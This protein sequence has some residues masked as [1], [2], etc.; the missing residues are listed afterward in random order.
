MSTF[1]NDFFVTTTQGQA[2]PGA[3]VYY[4]T[5]QSGATPQTV[6]LMVP[7]TLYTDSTGATT[8][9][10]PVI[11]D[12]FGHA[13]TG[14]LNVAPYLAAGTY[15]IAVVL[16]NGSIYEVLNDQLIGASGGGS[17]ISVFGR[18]GNVISA[19]NDY[20]FSQ[21]AGTITV[22]QLTG[23][24]F[25]ASGSSHSI[26]VVPDP[27]A[28]SGTTRFLREDA[29]WVVPSGSGGGGAGSNGNI[30]WNFDNAM[31]G[32]S[33]LNTDGNSLFAKGPIPYRDITSFEGVVGTTCFSPE[34]VT[35]S[36]TS[37]SHTL[38]V[39]G[40][41]WVNGCSVGVANAG[42]ATSLS[43]PTIASAAF[44]PATMQ[45]VANGFTRASN[46][47]HVALVND[48][49]IAV[50]DSVLIS[51]ATGCSTSPNI[52]ATVASTNWVAGA[53]NSNG[54]IFTFN[55]SGAN[56]TCGGNNGDGTGPA[57]LIV[58]PASTH[59]SYK[60][61]A[62]DFNNG[63]TAPSSAATI[64]T[65]VPTLQGMEPNTVT[66]NCVAGAAT[67]PVWR[68][69][70]GTGNFVYIGSALPCMNGYARQTTTLIDFGQ[71]FGAGTIPQIPVGVP[72][73]APS[74]A[75][76]QILISQITAGGGTDTLTLA[77]TASSSVSSTTTYHDNTTAFN[78]A[79]TAARTDYGGND[80]VIPSTIQPRF[81]NIDL[82]TP[83]V[84]PDGVFNPIV[85]IKV[86]GGLWPSCVVHK[87]FS[88]YNLIGTG[89]W[90]GDS[91]F[92]KLET[93][94]SF[95]TGDLNPTIFD[96]SNHSLIKGFTFGNSPQ[97]GPGLTG[98]A[99]GLSAFTAILMG[100][101]SDNLYSDLTTGGNGNGIS[102][103]LV[104]DGCSGSGG[105]FGLSFTRMNFDGSVNFPV[106]SAAFHCSGD[107]NL[108]SIFI[109]QRPILFDSYE[110]VADGGG[111]FINN[112]QGY[113]G[114]E[115]VHEGYL[116][117]TNWAN[118]TNIGGVSI[119]NLNPADSLYGPNGI[120]NNVTSTSAGTLVINGS[121]ISNNLVSG[122]PFASALFTNIGESG[123]GIQSKG[124]YAN[125]GQSA[126][127]IFS[128]GAG[129]KNT[130][131][132]VLSGSALIGSGTQPGGA[133][134]ITVVDQ[135]SGGTGFSSSSFGGDSGGQLL[136]LDSADASSSQFNWTSASTAAAVI[137][138][139]T[140]DALSTGN[141]SVQH[142]SSGGS[143]TLSQNN[144]H[145]S[146]YG[147]ASGNYV[148]GD[149]SL[150]GRLGFAS[151]SDPMFLT[152]SP[153]A[154]RTFTFPDI[155][156]TV[157]VFFA[158]GTAT[159]GTSAI[160]SGTCASAVTVA[161]TGVLTTDIVGAGFSGDPTSITGY[162]PSTAGMLTIIPYPTSGNVNFKVCNNTASSV[163]PGS[164][165]LNWRVAR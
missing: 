30:Q 8:A 91:G 123:I 146:L 62:M 138:F 162:M 48:A 1:R 160:A 49:S 51:G 75:L 82:T 104:T 22:A 161:A 96:E 101:T 148:A 63:I 59:Y 78:A 115:A 112:F 156:G 15:T 57:T 46:V 71:T 98:N 40:G 85:N 126:A 65:S 119:N 118:S 54:N 109:G 159:L 100:N 58:Q 23:T 106:P 111:L 32:A 141:I 27:G 83:P 125:L 113:G 144:F 35:G 102:P 158:S 55:Q 12:N 11:T 24:V 16:T 66:I 165:T 121:T 133:T 38:T 134:G 45:I 43:T 154:T 3:S 117:Q 76:G 39:S 2:I 9:S 21:I 64:T 87:V 37:G 151:D 120:I 41:T 135:V 29:T 52:T 72:I 17:V 142:N 5:N 94:A 44:T 88:T 140:L 74:G 107:L 80:V 150:P 153:T 130:A 36:M 128:N 47:V 143:L 6:N 77:G 86:A 152:G 122:Q 99:V 157:G 116:V 70:A 163:T 149:L 129:I 92:N 81:C 28:T 127:S 139:Y 103:G 147:E 84:T 7:V 68:Q 50:G 61:S 14:A 26:G 69:T 20:A 137:N 132:S 73:N 42:P 164:L 97:A 136:W 124:A 108:N 13:S 89:G 56:E 131:I 110:T 19:A 95:V 60:V 33:G 105:N 31:A 53:N 145:V 10:N 18:T 114:S 25:G 34:T 93:S 79:L 67:Y 155:S 90:T 4:L